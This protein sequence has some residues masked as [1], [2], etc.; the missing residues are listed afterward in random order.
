[1]AIIGLI[2]NYNRNSLSKN[3][4]NLL[5][6]MWSILSIMSEYITVLYSGCI[7]GKIVMDDIIPY[8]ALLGII[9]FILIT[10]CRVLIYMILSPVLI[11]IGYYLGYTEIMVWILT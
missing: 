10:V 9:L 4:D 2:Y 1:M 7:I 3:I 8:D 11:H 6:G 5:C